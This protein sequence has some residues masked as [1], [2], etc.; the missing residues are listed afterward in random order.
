MGPALLNCPE[1][2]CFPL[3][4]RTGH[5]F[6]LGRVGIVMSVMQFV[7]KAA[8]LPNSPLTDG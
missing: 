3:V 4:V 6:F 8:I 5:N 7:G 1:I 2:T